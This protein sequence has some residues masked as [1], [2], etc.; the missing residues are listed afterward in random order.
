MTGWVAAAVPYFKFVHIAAL[1]LWCGGLL[2]LPL[3]IARHDPANKLKDFVLIRRATHLTYTM[4][5]TPAAVIAVIAG[6]WLIFLQEALTPWLYAKL[7]FVALL[8]AAHAWVG[9]IIVAVAESKRERRPPP[10]VL[11]IAAALLP[12]L[13]ILALV[14][15]K[16]DLS[17]VDLPGW[18]M[19]PRGGQLPFDVPSR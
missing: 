14:L 7:V 1:V 9:H 13:A 16:P 3:M 10:A 18:L 6:T 8:V 2:V 5:L 19:Q 15:G 17:G 4:A 12:M 11:P